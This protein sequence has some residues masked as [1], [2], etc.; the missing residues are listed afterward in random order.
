MM[1][2][3]PVVLDGHRAATVMTKERTLSQL[4]LVRSNR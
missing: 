1:R 3:S 4:R 2:T